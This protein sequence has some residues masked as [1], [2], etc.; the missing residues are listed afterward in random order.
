MFF[1]YKPIDRDAL[2]R[3]AMSDPLD[4]ADVARACA[5]VAESA[6]KW[7]GNLVLLAMESMPRAELVAAAE[8]LRKD[9]VF[10]H[11]IVTSV[12]LSIP[13]DVLWKTMNAPHFERTNL[14]VDR[15]LGMQ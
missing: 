6:A 10:M 8:Q 2:L 7:E 1:G 15:L 11:E 12:Q 3:A 9:G 4:D 13:H 5:L 14:I